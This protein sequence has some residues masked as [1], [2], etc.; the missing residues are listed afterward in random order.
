MSHQRGNLP[1]AE[2]WIKQ[3]LQV[4]TDAIM[5]GHMGN[6]QSEMN[7][8]Q[9]AEEYFRRAL[10]VDPAYANVYF[11]YSNL[12]QRQQRGREAE[13]ALLR[14]LQIAPEFAEANLHLGLMLQQNRQYGAAEFHYRRTLMTRPDFVEALVNLAE[15]LKLT[16]RVLEA[17]LYLKKAL[18]IAPSFAKAVNNLGVLY[19]EIGRRDAAKICY[20]R[21][22]TVEPYHRNIYLNLA[23]LHQELQQYPQAR[24]YFDNALAVDA[25]N[26][27]VRFNYGLFLLLQGDYP[28]GWQHYEARW[29]TADAEK[30][31]N[32]AQP[33]WLGNDDIRGKTIMLHAEQGLGD[34]LQFVRYANLLHARGA[35]VLMQAPSSLK[36]LL[37]S[38][39][40]V[41]EVYADEDS[42]PAFDYHTPLMSLPFLCG[43]TIATIPVA[44]PYLFA[45]EDAIAH[46]SRKLGKC[47]A[48]R[49]GLVWAGAARREQA[50]A[51][52]V[53]KQRSI[54]FRQLRPLL[55]VD[56]VEFHS[57]QVSD[58]ARAQ[59]N[60]V[61]CIVDHGPNL[62]DFADT[63]A[64]V[65]NLD[66]VICVDTSIAHLAGALGKPF[67]LLNR[68][69]TCWR[70]LSERSD[71]PWY[72][73]ARLFRQA[74]PGDWASVILDV[75]NALEGTAAAHKVENAQ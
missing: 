17:E 5:L 44:T 35:R 59:L 51:Y 58:E 8:A 46:W 23:H 41:A 37:A 10:V 34:T 20:L 6:L 1:A 60:S 69:N 25:S 11:N 50:A 56:G 4:R 18:T 66:L 68:Y 30:M 22:L 2:A 65:A 16:H 27:Q 14:A 15:V 39:A 72:P 43:T 21:V 7:R 38:C 29:K 45:R 64:L 49:V 48:L 74:R 53:D 24:H 67:W 26:P 33:R 31:R 40:G 54:E 28:R 61:D 32:F 57:L 13:L 73:S 47:S 70:W 19:N 52:V 75:R 63:A 3:A 71:S 42:L 36:R 9:N 62:H 12:L 55:E